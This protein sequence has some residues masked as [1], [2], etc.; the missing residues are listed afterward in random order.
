M[1]SRW[2]SAW[3]CVYS[4]RYSRSTA[5]L[6]IPMPCSVRRA[7]VS[8]G[9]SPRGP[10]P[11]APPGD[12][13]ATSLASGRGAGAAGVPG[14]AREAGTAGAS[15]AAII[16]ASQISTCESAPPPP[17]PFVTLRALEPAGAVEQLRGRREGSGRESYQG[18]LLQAARCQAVRLEDLGR[19]DETLEAAGARVIAAGRHEGAEENL[20]IT[21]VHATTLPRSLVRLCLQEERPEGGGDRGGRNEGRSVGW[22]VVRAGQG[23]G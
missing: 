1:A 9:D 18:S 16:S 13:E 15:G 10:P 4:P 11:S 8:A 20:G 5:S 6:L 21:R 19:V 3:A 12:A 2:C 23:Q 7:S 14:R 17:P 22:P